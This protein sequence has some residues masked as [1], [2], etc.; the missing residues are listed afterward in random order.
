MGDT[1]FTEY[2]GGRTVDVFGACIELTEINVAA[3]NPT[4]SSQDGVLFN[5][6]ATI[7]ICYPAGR[8]GAYAIPDTVTAIGPAAFEW[9]D[10]MTS[11]TIPQGVTTIERRTFSGCRVLNELVIPEGVT[12]I[13]YGAFSH[14]Y[15][16]TEIT[17]PDGVTTIED[18]AF[19]WCTSLKTVHIPASVTSIDNDMFY[20]T[21]NA[22]IDAPEGSYAY[23]WAKANNRLG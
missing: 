20:A 8:Q 5:K 17:I 7:L 19:A 6:D 12:K 18:W 9:A 2:D 1:I 13:K 11:V 15:K 4:Y 3:G 21:E 22:V 16:L 10:E 23:E 14:C